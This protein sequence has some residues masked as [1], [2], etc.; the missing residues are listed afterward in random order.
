MEESL[1]NIVDDRVKELTKTQ[2]SLYV[3]KGLI[4]ERKQNPADVAKM[5][6]DAIQQEYKNLR[7]EIT[8]Q[9][10]NAITNYIP[11]QDDPHDDAHPKGQYSAKR[12]KTSEHGTYV[13]GESSFGQANESEPE[14]VEE[15]SETVDEAKLLKVVDEMLRQRCTS[16][17]EH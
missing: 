5:I 15:M 9:I 10:N 1:P 4:M 11:S 7:A 2:V 17:D 6:A 14:F 16:G 13:F 8:S 3:A 12:L